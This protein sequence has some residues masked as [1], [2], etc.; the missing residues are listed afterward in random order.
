MTLFLLRV[1]LLGMEAIIATIYLFDFLTHPD[2]FLNRVRDEALALVVG[3][4]LVFRP[5]ALID[6]T[7]FIFL[8]TFGVVGLMLAREFVLMLL[9]PYIPF[10][11]TSFMLL[12][13]AAS[14]WVL[15]FLD[16]VVLGPGTTQYLW[17]AMAGMFLFALYAFAR[18]VL[19][20]GK[21][22]FS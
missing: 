18:A 2:H 8:I 5:V 14:V 4:L 21:S 22:D 20:F 3:V 10:G 1:F 15:W 13:S 12:F 11:R 17:G 19:A 7:N 6:S 16:P 9:T